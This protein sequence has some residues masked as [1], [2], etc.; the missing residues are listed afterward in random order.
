MS[1][2]SNYLS[3]FWFSNIRLKSSLCYS[4]CTHCTLLG[5]E[6]ANCVLNVKIN[7]MSFCNM[8]Y[9]YLTIEALVA[10]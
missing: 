9:F 7:K 1:E 3:Q 5:E 4:T 8:L 2:E 6:L 10:F